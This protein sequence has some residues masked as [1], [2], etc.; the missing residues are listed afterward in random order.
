MVHYDVLIY[1][2]ECMSRHLR[3]VFFVWHEVNFNKYFV[4]RRVL[5]VTLRI[6]TKHEKYV[7]LPNGI[8]MTEVTCEQESRN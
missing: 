8:W 3:P 6:D 5:I 2:Y 1:M 4:L 7:L